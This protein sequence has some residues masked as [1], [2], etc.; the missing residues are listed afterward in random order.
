MRQCNTPFC[1]VF[2]LECHK[3]TEHAGHGISTKVELD[4]PIYPQTGFEEEDKYKEE[5]K[6]H[7][8]E[9]RD[10]RTQSR[11]YININKELTPDFTYWDLQNLL[12]EIYAK[13]SNAFKIN[14]GFGFKLRHV[15]TR[16]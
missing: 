12:D 2:E 10:K 4:Q 16:I 11:Y 5:I 6:N 3:R 13:Q 8:V 15:V 7:W 14:L 9:I 1:Q